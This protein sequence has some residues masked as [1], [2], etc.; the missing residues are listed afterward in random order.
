M[1]LNMMN[2]IAPM[3]DESHERLLKLDKLL[4]RYENPQSTW[5]MAADL[6]DEL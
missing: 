1:F 2:V 4:S 3:D 5:R 6:R